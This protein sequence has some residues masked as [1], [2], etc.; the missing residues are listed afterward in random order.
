MVI[1]VDISPAY[2]FSVQVS[3]KSMET[4]ELVVRQIVLKSSGLNVLASKGSF[5]CEY[6]T[7]MLEISKVERS[8]QTEFAL[9]TMV[10]MVA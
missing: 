9:D 6:W 1:H 5:L 8:H 7:S 10:T 4:V 2:V 3:L